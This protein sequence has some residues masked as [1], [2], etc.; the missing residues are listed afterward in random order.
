MIQKVNLNRLK[1]DFVDGLEIILEQVLNW[2]QPQHQS[3]GCA[4][5]TVSHHVTS[6]PSLEQVTAPALNQLPSW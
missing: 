2:T 4:A 5:R 3:V 6:H 1:E